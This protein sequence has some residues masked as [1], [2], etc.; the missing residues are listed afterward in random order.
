MRRLHIIVALGLGLA[1]PGM[2]RAQAPG[3]ATYWRSYRV[4]EGR[5]AEFREGYAR[6]LRWHLAHR[7]PWP[8][9]VWEE[10][11]GPETGTFIGAAMDRP[12]AELDARPRPAEDAADHARQIDPHVEPVFPASLLRR[13]PDLGGELPPLEA[14]P[15]LAVIEVVVRP[16]RRAAF[17]AALREAAGERGGRFGWFEVVVGGEE[18]AY[19]YLEPH[20][21]ASALGAFSAAG[22][23]GRALD[24]V[25]SMRTRL[26]RFLPELSSC[27]RAESRCLGVAGR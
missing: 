14:A 3:G 22:R 7:D 13:R 24:A 12:W 11:R 6:H 8:W 23:L 16:D 20:P 4:T 19:L 27:Q 10:I 5:E 26:L 17:E 25:A 18:P 9:Y 21:A 15:F 2:A 1:A